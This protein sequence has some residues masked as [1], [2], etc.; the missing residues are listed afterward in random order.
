MQ[1]KYS[2]LGKK[3]LQALAELGWTQADLAKESGISRPTINSIIKGKTSPTENTLRIIAKS[4]RKQ[5]QYLFE[6]AQFNLGEN[7]T[8]AY[9][10]AN[11]EI[12]LL[13]KDMEILKLKMER[14][15]K[16]K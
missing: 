13:K 12:E 4:L 15:E 7:N 6:N 8:I 5:P 1:S 10:S 2:D 3:I 14:L 16:R 11:Q 9:N